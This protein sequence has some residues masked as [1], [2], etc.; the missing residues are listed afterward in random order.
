MDPGWGLGLWLTFCIAL[1]AGFLDKSFIRILAFPPGEHATPA[2]RI[3]Q[4][5]D[6]GTTSYKYQSRQ[7]IEPTYT[8]E[9][10]SGGHSEQY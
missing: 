3:V 5:T 2:A 6:M 1:G 4:P 7:L 10:R 9:S 8:R